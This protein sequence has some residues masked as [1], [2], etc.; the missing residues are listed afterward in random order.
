MAILRQAVFLAP[1]MDTVVSVM[2]RAVVTLS[3]LAAAIPNP[4]NPASTVN[5]SFGSGGGAVT[6]PAAQPGNL[7][8]A[9]T[10]EKTGYE[11]SSN[12]DFYQRQM[13][14]MRTAQSGQKLQ[15]LAAAMR[16]QE[17]AQAPQGEPFGG[18]PWSWANLPEVQ[19]GGSAQATPIEWGL[20][21]AYGI[22]PNMT[23]RQAVG[24]LSPVLNTDEIAI[25]NAHWANAPPSATNNNW[26]TSNPQALSAQFSA[27]ASDTVSPEFTNVMQKIFN[28]LYTQ[29]GG[30]TGGISVPDG[31]ANPVNTQGV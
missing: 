13:Q 16:R 23:N 14:E 15:D 25:M 17:A 31:Y 20:N 6:G 24:A 5:E 22:N 2:G 21:E 19:M 9:I 11:S 29:T 3:A 12:K 28:N 4:Q 18:D 10:P 7:L 26:L 1:V 8:D 30:G 27:N